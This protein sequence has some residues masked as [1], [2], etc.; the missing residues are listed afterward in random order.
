MS[1]YAWSRRKTAVGNLFR[2]PSFTPQAPV[3]GKT[4]T[5]SSPTAVAKVP[6]TAVTESFA[7]YAADRLAGESRGTDA[8]V[9]KAPPTAGGGAA[10]VPADV[11][12]G[13]C[14]QIPPPAHCLPPCPEGQYRDLTQRCVLPS[15]PVEGPSAVFDWRKILFAVG[16]FVAGAVAVRLVRR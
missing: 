6:T 7:D 5:F 9:E 4:P 16:G 13:E 8:V 11:P 14:L 10:D 12:T 2:A 1:Y 15:S 3:V